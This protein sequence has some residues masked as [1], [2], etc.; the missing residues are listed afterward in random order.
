MQTELEKKEILRLSNVESNRI[1]REC[2]QLSLVKLMGQKPFDQITITEITKNA[3]VSRTAFYRNYDSKEAIIEDVC[4][5]VFAK[6]GDSLRRAARDQDW[7]SWYVLFFESIRSNREYV[8]IYLDAHLQPENLLL[9]DS[10][11]PPDTTLAHYT[12]SAREGAFL[13]IFTDWFRS[14]MQ[15]SPEDMGDICQQILS[16]IGR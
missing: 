12:N 11:F 5:S 15:E 6:L 2:L 13:R 14:G 8:Q 10:V 16:P 7:R 4:Q 1:T 9:M 3:G